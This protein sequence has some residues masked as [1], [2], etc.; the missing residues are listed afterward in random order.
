MLVNI[1]NDTII[2]TDYIFKIK[3][4]DDDTYQVKLG[5]ELLSI[6]KKDFNKIQ[7]NM[8]TMQKYMATEKENNVLKSKIKTLDKA[9]EDMTYAFMSYLFALYQLQFSYDKE[10]KTIS[11][12]GNIYAVDLDDEQWGAIDTLYK[13]WQSSKKEFLE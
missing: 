7:S 9:S 11:V 12:K 2:N 13:I 1:K 8:P 4:M 3:K 10:L 6:S 5:D